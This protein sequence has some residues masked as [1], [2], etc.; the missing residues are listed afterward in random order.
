VTHRNTRRAREGVHHRS[1]SL[2]RGNHVDGARPLQRR[3]DIGVLERLPDETSGIDA[4]N[5][6][7][8]DGRKVVSEP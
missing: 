6:G 5:G 4:V 8:N 2:P 1:R 3:D 7:A